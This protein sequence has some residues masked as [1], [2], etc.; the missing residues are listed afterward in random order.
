MSTDNYSQQSALDYHKNHPSGKIGIK[1]LKPINNEDDLAKAY[2]PGVALVVEE[3]VKNPENAYLYTNKSHLVAVITNGTAVLGLGNTGALASKPVMEGKAALIKAQSGLDAIDIEVDC[4]DPSKL[5]EIIASIS[6]SFGGILLEDIKAPECFEVERKLQ[7][8]L[9]IPVFHDDQH[10]TAIVV[11]A[12]LINGLKHQAKEAKDCTVVLIGAGAAGYAIFQM[13]TSLGIQKKNI[14]V[15]DRSGHIHNGRENL[16][17]HKKEFCAQDENITL[18]DSFINTDIVIGVSG[19]DLMN[20][21]DLMA[22]APNALIFA[23]S[24]PNPEIDPSMVSK[25]RPDIILCTG[26]SD[27]KNQVN[28]LVAFPYLLKSLVQ[29]RTIVPDSDVKLKMA[30][31]IAGLSADAGADELIPKGLDPRLKNL[32][33]MM[34]SYLQSR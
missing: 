17:D 19:P 28:N 9:N 16:P 8:R 2:T 20:K 27:L 5:V 3:I 21:D 26:R 13:L 11:T 1:I 12:A 23:L 34:V 24:N 30:E 22:L 18:K 14:R 32:T 25:H 15:Y 33:E 10:G 4:N 31:L 29:T 6:P 7:E